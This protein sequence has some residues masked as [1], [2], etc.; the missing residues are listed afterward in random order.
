MGGEVQEKIHMT[1]QLTEAAGGKIAVKLGT[2]RP[3]DICSCCSLY[4]AI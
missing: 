4:S 2:K 1:S 3:I